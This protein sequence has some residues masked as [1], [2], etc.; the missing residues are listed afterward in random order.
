MS[1][2][3]QLFFAAIGD[4]NRSEPEKLAHLN[5]G[6]D[7]IRCLLFVKTAPHQAP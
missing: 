5:F 2:N 1:K 6:A 3:C 7:L 4:D